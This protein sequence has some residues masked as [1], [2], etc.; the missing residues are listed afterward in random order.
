MDNRKTVP[1]LPLEAYTDQEW[2]DREQERIFSRTWAFAGLAEDITEPGQYVSVQAGLNNIFIVMGEDRKL[3]AFH[4][5]CRHRGH[6]CCGPLARRAR[7]S[8]AHTTTGPTTLKA[9]CARC[10][11][12]GTSS[13]TWT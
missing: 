7:L 3:R 13:P 5:I 1:I 9:A 11:T 6:S 2:F 10:P 8:P 4:N 12:E